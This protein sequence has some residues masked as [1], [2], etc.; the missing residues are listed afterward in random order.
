MQGFYNTK[1]EKRWSSQEDENLTSTC[2]DT[3]EELVAG[4]AI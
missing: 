3:R 1:L 4:D 2:W